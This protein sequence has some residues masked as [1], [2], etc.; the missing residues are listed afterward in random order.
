MS[1]NSTVKL[2]IAMMAYNEEENLGQLLPGIRKSLEDLNVSYEIL[3]IDTIEAMDNTEKVC[4]GFDNVSYIKRRTSN[5]YGDAIRTAIATAK[6]QFLLIMDSDGSHRPEFIPEMIKDCDR[7]DLTVA[8]RYMPGG[9]SDNSVM[10]VLLSKV[11]NSCYALLLNLQCT[12]VSNSFRVY[13]IEQLRDLDLKCQNFD[14]MEEILYKLSYFNKDLRINEIPYHFRKR[15]H[16]ESRRVFIV[17]AY[18]YFLTLIKLLFLKCRMKDA[19]LEKAK[20]VRGE[21]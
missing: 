14:I 10:L 15:V 13:R 7:Y 2:S 17:F 3:V 4:S 8:S 11:V 12:D 19:K 9:R 16:G 6:G 18:S 5:S 21:L 1:E 20:V